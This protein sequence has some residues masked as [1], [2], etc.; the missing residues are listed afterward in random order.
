MS[1]NDYYHL[2]NIVVKRVVQGGSLARFTNGKNSKLYITD[3]E[4]SFS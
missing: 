3:I 2:L 4:I 1:I